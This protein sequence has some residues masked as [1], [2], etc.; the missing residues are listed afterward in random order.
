MKKILLLLLLVAQGAFAQNI[1]GS[2]HGVLEAGPQKLNLIFDIDKAAN[3][4]KLSVIEQGIK[5]L[6]ME[7]AYLSD[8]S[9]SV[10]LA[11]S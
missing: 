2:W 9:V 6:P 3:T 1:N 4:V 5:G 11:Q 8:D 10:F 7:V